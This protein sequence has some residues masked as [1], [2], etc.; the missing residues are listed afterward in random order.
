MGNSLARTPL[1]RGLEREYHQRI[2]PQIL[3]KEQ[4]GAIRDGDHVR[5][6]LDC[7]KSRETPTCDIEYGHRCTSAALIANIALR[8]K[9][10]LEWNATTER[11]TNHA[12]ANELLSYRYREPYKLS[13]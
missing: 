1:A 6:F 3:A 11:F 10:F 7:V 9:S 4:Q 8:T 2:E 13:W 5:S 12:A